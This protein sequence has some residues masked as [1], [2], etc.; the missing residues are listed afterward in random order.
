[1][2]S[3]G[4]ACSEAFCVRMDIM[5]GRLVCTVVGLVP[6]S[7]VMAGIEGGGRAEWGRGEGKR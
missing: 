4:G 6:G 5:G 3:S 1:M 7:A 2:E